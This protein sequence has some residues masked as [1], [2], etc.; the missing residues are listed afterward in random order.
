MATLSEVKFHT[1]S[2]RILS[3][4]LSFSLSV[5]LSEKHTKHFAPF[6]ISR[7]KRSRAN[8]RVKH[9]RQCRYSNGSRFF[10]SLLLSPLFS[11]LS[12]S[13][14]ARFS[15]RSAYIRALLLRSFNPLPVFPFFSFY[16]WRI[17][18][19]YNYGMNLDE[20]SLLTFVTYTV[21]IC[22]STFKRYL[23]LFNIFII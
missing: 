14:I 1:L 23:I 9:A 10:S 16:L 3:L 22:I 17:N 5:P 2:C 12:L 19:P 4:P 8:R 21:R 18:S 20:V 6:P 7:E 13:R 15:L 11:R